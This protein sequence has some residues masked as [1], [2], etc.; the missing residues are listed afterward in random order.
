MAA[1]G[2]NRQFPIYEY[3]LAIE[4]PAAAAADAERLLF[5]TARR[6]RLVPIK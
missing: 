6:V 4:A 5:E 1:M 2:K 3:K